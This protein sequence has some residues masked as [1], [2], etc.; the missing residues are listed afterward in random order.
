L[1]IERRGGAAVDS[2]MCRMMGECLERT[3]GAK[4][5]AMAF[6]LGWWTGDNEVRVVSIIDLPLLSMYSMVRGFE[7]G[8]R[9]GRSQ[10]RYGSLHSEE[11]R[12]E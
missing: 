8:G 3:R 10:C 4:L 11:G 7:T 5:A 6:S 9:D 1:R 12:M 2:R